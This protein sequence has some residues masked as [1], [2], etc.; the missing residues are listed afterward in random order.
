MGHL[1]GV[2]D[3]SG[4]DVLAMCRAVSPGFSS[5]LSSAAAGGRWSSPP[6]LLFAFIHSLKSF[7]GQGKFRGAD[8]NLVAKTPSMSA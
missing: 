8:S 2:W 6:F 3:S 4:L 7:V 1:W 5:A